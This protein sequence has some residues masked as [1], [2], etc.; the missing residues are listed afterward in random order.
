MDNL[1]GLL[2]IRKMDKVLNAWIREL[3][4]VMKGVDKR[5]NEDVFRWFG[6]VERMKNDMI[7]DRG[8]LLCCSWLCI[9]C[10]K[11]MLTF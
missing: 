9:V 2:G 10:I 11:C 6:H 3:C 8:V 1:T 7:V 5:I 4:R